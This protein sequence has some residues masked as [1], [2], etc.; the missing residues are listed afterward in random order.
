VITRRG[1][2]VVSLTV[3]SFLYVQN[4]YTTSKPRNALK[5]SE[6]FLDVNGWIILE[7][8]LQ[9]IEVT[10]LQAMSSQNDH[11]RKSDGFFRKL[12]RSVSEFFS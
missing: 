10:K 11:R 9:Q 6:V 12:R 8:N 2:L 7:N 1:F 4:G 5:N 3:L